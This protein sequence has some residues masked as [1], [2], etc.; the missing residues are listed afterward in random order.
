MSILSRLFGGA[1]KPE[2]RA[3]VAET[4]KECR[5]TA[6]P[7]ATEG[8]YR[9]GARIEKEIGGTAKVHH[10]MRADTLGSLDEAEAF[11]IRKAKQ[12]IDEQGDAIFG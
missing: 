2:A 4:Y 1:A 8:G 7:E 12:V 3:E 9:V 6:V 11:S 5:I 10:L